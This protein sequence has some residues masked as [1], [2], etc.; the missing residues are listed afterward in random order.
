MT[1]E[2]NIFRYRVEMSFPNPKSHATLH[3]DNI[4]IEYPTI[5]LIIKQIKVRNDRAFMKFN[6][7]ARTRDGGWKKG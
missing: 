4:I 5:K 2:Q 3:Q 6:L 7:V 1:F